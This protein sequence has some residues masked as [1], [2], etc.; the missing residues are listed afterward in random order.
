MRVIRVAAAVIAHRCANILGHAVEL[1]DQ[2]LDREL[3]QIG[4]AFESFV[5]IR[6]VSA[7][8]LVVMDFHRLRVD[9]GLERVERVRKRRQ[10]MGGLAAAP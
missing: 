10:D 3:L 1:R 8:M 5:Q 6:D 2:L 9:V 7:V 4:V